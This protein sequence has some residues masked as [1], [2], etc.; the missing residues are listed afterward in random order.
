LGAFW[1]NAVSNALGDEIGFPNDPSIVLPKAGLQIHTVGGDIQAMFEGL[2]VEFNDGT[3]RRN[4][5]PERKADDVWGWQGYSV[6]VTQSGAALS[7]ESPDRFRRRNY[8]GVLRQ[9]DRLK[10]GD[11]QVLEFLLRAN[12]QAFKR[13]QH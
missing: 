3:T 11:A 4:A 9:A 1:L 5:I 8:S 10:R 13:T 7:L 6:D 2:I 12:V